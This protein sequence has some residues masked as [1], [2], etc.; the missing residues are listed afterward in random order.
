MGATKLGEIGMKNSL[1]GSRERLRA[2]SQ[3]ENCPSEASIC[4]RHRKE[5]DKPRAG[6]DQKAQD[7]PGG[8]S[9]L[10]CSRLEGRV[11][12]R[13]VTEGPC[14]ARRGQSNPACPSGHLLNTARLGRVR[15]A[16]SFC[17]NSR[18]EH[19]SCSQHL[20]E[21]SSGLQ[22][23]PA[24]A[25]ASSGVPVAAPIASQW[26]PVRLRPRNSRHGWMEFFQ[27]CHPSVSVP[28]P[29]A[30]PGPHPPGLHPRARPERGVRL[31]DTGNAGTSSARGHLPSRVIPPPGPSP[32][33]QQGLFLRECHL[34]HP[35]QGL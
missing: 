26:T 15:R 4:P 25:W 5:G 18:R 34:L 6:E 3:A 29:P 16:R 23:T 27:R 21:E 14:G 2:L 33:W 7:T 20:P 31:R 19:P 13:I 32:L 8:G 30:G 17:E 9:W 22:G 24:P 28:L 10:P 35:G 11:E 1:S 12:T